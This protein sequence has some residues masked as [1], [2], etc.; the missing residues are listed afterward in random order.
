M[1]D[2]AQSII[3]VVDGKGLEAQALVLAASITRHHDTGV[4]VVAYLSKASQTGLDPA[5]RALFEACGVAVAPLPDG[6]GRW[7]KD[8][9]H[10]NKLLA[11][12]APRDCLR[13]TFVDTDVF[14]Q[15][16][17][18]NL[19][20]QDPLEVFAVPEGKPTWGK[21]GDAWERVYKFFDL[22][23][24]TARV[25]LMRGRRL[26]YL[27][28]F[29]A[30]FVSFSER[31]L[32]DDGRAF[33]QMW[34]EMASRFDWHCPVANKRPWTDQIILPLVMAEYGLTCVTL[35][36]IYNYS[37]SDRVD[38]TDLPQARMVH[39]HR[40]GYFNTLPDAAE[41]LEDVYQRTPARHHAGL[42]DLLKVFTEAA[43]LAK[44]LDPDEA[45]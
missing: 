41:L 13:T 19:P 5:T 45:A 17:I 2:P 6:T 24:P 27:P 8:Y 31:P 34:L 42:A 12:S 16:P 40:A 22:P 32:E 33:G 25:T 10:G 23:M 14:C 26:Q 28:Y 35:P 7:K 21:S 18:T 38:L 15:A 4:Q 44:V 11:C 20:E 37:I 9:P 3:F 39:Y 1:A 29:N 43:P 36:E 30:G